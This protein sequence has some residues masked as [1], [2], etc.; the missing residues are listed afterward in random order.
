MYDEVVENPYEE[1]GGNDEEAL[2]GVINIHF[3]D[4]R[5]WIKEYLD[6]TKKKVGGATKCAYLLHEGMLIVFSCCLSM[7]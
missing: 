2:T 6:A 1:S 5:M 7:L 3:P 4:M